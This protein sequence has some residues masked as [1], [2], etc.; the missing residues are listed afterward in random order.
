MN[1]LPVDNTSQ[2]QNV[3]MTLLAGLP[4]FTLLPLGLDF[5]LPAMYQI[6]EYF[7]NQSV[8]PMAISVYMLFWG[9]G[10]LVWGGIADLIGKK[11]IAAIGLVIFTFASFMITTSN[12]DAAISFL[13]FRALQSFGG[14]AC[15]TAIFALIRT[16]FDGDELNKSY[17]YL[18]GILAFIPVSAP[19]LGAYILENNPWLYLFS[20][21]TVLGLVSLLWIALSLP[22]DRN[23]KSSTEQVKDNTS[24]LQRYCKVLMNTRFRSY[25]L[26][27]ATGQMLFIYY[28]TVAPTF[29]IGRLGVSQLEFGQMFMIIAVVFMVISFAAPKLNQYMT[30]RSII[31]LA[32]LLI[33]IGSIAMYT[34]ST[35]DVWYAFIGPM[36]PIAVGCT[37]LLSCC[38]ANALA[39]FKHIS[40][41]ASGLYTSITFGMGSLV[42]SVFVHLIDSSELGLVSWVYLACSLLAILLLILNETIS[43]DSGGKE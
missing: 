39:D 6:G 29:L 16:R 9:I 42:S 25:L 19:L 4:L 20:I 43:R 23:N 41:V 8:P 18:N 12:P 31:Y 36:T 24:T 33:T 10:Q 5:F 7:D 35:M 40:G 30:I 21:M 32:L 28:L 14:S 2:K 11:R 38:P 1:T 17:S 26:F 15:F 37:I 3:G 13:F 34:M 27:A 22:A